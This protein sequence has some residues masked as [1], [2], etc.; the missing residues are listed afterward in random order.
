MHIQRI[1]PGLF[2]ARFAAAI[3]A[4]ALCAINAAAQNPE[5]QSDSTFD[6]G[7]ILSS[8]D[9]VGLTISSGKRFN[10]VEGLPIF[11]GPTYKNHFG[12][13]SVSIAALGIMRSAN[14]FHWDDQ[15]LGHRL[16]ADVRFGGHRGFAVGAV[17]YV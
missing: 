10:R 1:I 13:A 6:L 14:K 5:T 3:C 8:E 9:R 7:S 4:S 12:H 15:N 11:I 17:S 16:K 2:R